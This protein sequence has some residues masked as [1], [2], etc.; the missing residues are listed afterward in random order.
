MSAG[1][2]ASPCAY[3]A[4]EDGLHIGFSRLRNY[5][6]AEAPSLR[7]IQKSET[8]PPGDQTSAIEPRLTESPTFRFCS[9][10]KRTDNVASKR[11]AAIDRRRFRRCVQ[12][13]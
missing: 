1:L 8:V 2:S 9:T 11:P 13:R 7:R 12:L 4:S 5:G 10:S 3:A 6:E